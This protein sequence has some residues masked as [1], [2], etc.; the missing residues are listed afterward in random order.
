[1]V[2]GGSGRGRR[3]TSEG[4]EWW[5]HDEVAGLRPT[6][7]VRNDQRNDQRIGRIR[8]QFRLFK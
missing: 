4:F 2:V 7:P 3:M 8:K 5:V 1:M 6:Q